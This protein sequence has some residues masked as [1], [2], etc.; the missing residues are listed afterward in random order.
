MNQKLLGSCACKN[1][2][3]EVSG[4]ILMAAH[5]HCR[6]CQRASGSG[7]AAV[8]AVGR[9]ELRI[10]GDRASY[11]VAG[12]SG[13]GVRR[14]FC[15]T[16]GSPVFTEAEILPDMVILRITS[17]DDPSQVAPSMHIYCES[18]QPW[19]I[20]DDDLPKFGRMPA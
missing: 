14:Y 4:P 20:P 12:D 15:P 16:C 3:Y 11:L 1:L 2:N 5:C 9:D 10:S 19:D 6:D 13:H 7:S 8:F 17:L 18:A